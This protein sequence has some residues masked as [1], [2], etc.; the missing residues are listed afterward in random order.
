VEFRGC[1]FENVR[2][3]ESA[4][5]WVVREYPKVARRAL[6]LVEGVSTIEGRMFA[7]ELRNALKMPG[8]VDS[9][10]VFNRADYVVAGGEA[11]AELA[12]KVLRE[13]GADIGG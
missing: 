1:R 2:L 8:S 11:L 10:G 7:G 5:V 13:A 9:I 12:E 6:A 4:G 3:P